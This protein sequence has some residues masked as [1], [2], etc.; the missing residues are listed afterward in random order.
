MFWS[1]TAL[2]RFTPPEL[3]EIR[4]V[5]A[6]APK[7][8]CP[9]VPKPRALTWAVTVRIEAAER[10][11]GVTCNKLVVWPFVIVITKGDDVLGLKL[12]SPE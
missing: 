4:P 3:R 1:R 9:F 10:I 8:C 12:A 2:P 6:L 11:D 7:P 5:G